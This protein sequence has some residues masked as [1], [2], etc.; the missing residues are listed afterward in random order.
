MD[1][2]IHCGHV[3]G[4]QNA[5]RN[6]IER[7]GSRHMTSTRFRK[8]AL[9]AI[10]ASQL[11]G[12]SL[13]EWARNQDTEPLIYLSLLDAIEQS[14][15][16]KING[17]DLHSH[18]IEFARKN[19]PANQVA[20]ISLYANRISRLCTSTEE[21]IDWAQMKCGALTPLDSAQAPCNDEPACGRV[22]FAPFVTRDPELMA[23]AT[24]ALTDPCRNI[25]DWKQLQRRHHSRDPRGP[26][27]T[28]SADASH[29]W[30]SCDRAIRVSGTLEPETTAGDFVI[31]WTRR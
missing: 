6:N 21:Q 10:L 7:S 29:F 12:C 17:D 15:S 16:L 24:A 8:L 18:Q 2:S 26:A 19:G 3:R 1:R 13:G 4:N 22:R 20:R 25:P 30:L 23:H 28:H 14:L 5:H 11:G 9:F 27:T 31:R